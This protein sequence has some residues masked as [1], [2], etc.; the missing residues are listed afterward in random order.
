MRLR[1]LLTEFELA[2][3]AYA[4]ADGAPRIFFVE[5]GFER[6]QPLFERMGVRQLPFVFH[7]GPAAALRPGKK[8]AV[9]KN[10]QVWVVVVVMMFLGRARARE[11][12]REGD[13]CAHPP[14][15]SSP[16][17]LLPHCTHEQINAHSNSRSPCPNKQT[18]K[19]KKTTKNSLARA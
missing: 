16:I 3:Q 17:F 8:I 1:E 5:L 2:A 7:W 6:S 15:S 18:N 4:R 9:P 19:H 10:E 12:E 13:D 11:R 14:P